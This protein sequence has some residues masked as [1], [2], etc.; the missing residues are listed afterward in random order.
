MKTKFGLFCL[1]SLLTV[2]CSEKDEPNPQ[3]A[4]EV[5]TYDFSLSFTPAYINTTEFELILSSEDCN[6]LLDTLL[7]V[8]KSHTLQLSTDLKE[9]D[10][11]TVSK[12]ENLQDPAYFLIRTYQKVK[13]NNWT[14]NENLNYSVNTYHEETTLTSRV[15]YTNLPYNF[16]GFSFHSTKPGFYTAGTSSQSRDIQIGS[17]DRVF[18][19]NY[20][21]LL[22]PDLGKYIYKSANDYD[23]TIDYSIAGDLVKHDFVKPA[24]LLLHYV[25][26][27]GFHHAGDYINPLQVYNTVKA[28]TSNGLINPIKN[29]LLYPPALFE[30]YELNLTFRNATNNELSFYRVTKEI[31]TDLSFLSE[32]DFTVSSSSSKVIQIKSGSDKPTNYTLKWFTADRNTLNAAWH[33]ILPDGNTSF[34]R[35]THE[36]NL[37]KSI[38]LKGKD[39]NVL[40]FPTVQWARATGY[41]YQSFLDYLFNP[42][43]MKRKEMKE[44]RSFTKGF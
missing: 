19:S 33:V 5:S 20:T 36:K 32:P 43:A 44:F 34:D 29:D 17:Y 23:V 38:L 35:G 8:S 39:L 10:V 24:G 18:P 2:A 16:G 6:I 3:P 26:L 22:L 28:K 41:T 25:N 40:Q 15:R 12:N 9:F 27:S 13:P 4:A 37:Q 42:E 14:L 30:N 21:Y 11:T 7:A 1:V 31:P